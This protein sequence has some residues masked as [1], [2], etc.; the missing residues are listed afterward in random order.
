MPIRIR[1]QQFEIMR[2]HADPD[3]DTDLDPKP[4]GGI[5]KSLSPPLSLSFSFS[6]YPSL[7]LSALPFYSLPS[8]LYLPSFLL[9]SFSLSL[10]P[11]EN[12]CYLSS[13]LPSYLSSFLYIPFFMN[14]IVTKQTLAITTFSP[15]LSPPSSSPYLLLISFASNITDYHC[16][17]GGMDLPPPPHN[18]WGGG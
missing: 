4:W 12:N 9:L 6:L 11:L 13:S 3:P 15:P 16:S 8:P 18:E 1:I 14:Q 2:I 7:L 5:Y 17:N 10:F